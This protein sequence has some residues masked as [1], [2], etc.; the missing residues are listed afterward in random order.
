M[1]CRTCSAGWARFA[2]ARRCRK[3][4]TRP[5]SVIDRDADDDKARQFAEEAR[6][7]VEMGQSRQG[8]V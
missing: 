2:P 3:A 4:S 5:P 8:G 7:M 6:Q 1:T